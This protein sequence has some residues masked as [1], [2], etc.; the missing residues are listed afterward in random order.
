MA[1]QNYND[2]YAH[3][4]HEIHVNRYTDTLGDVINVSIEC[5]DCYEVLIDFDNEGE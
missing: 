5:E 2:L 3:Y 1:I 4:G